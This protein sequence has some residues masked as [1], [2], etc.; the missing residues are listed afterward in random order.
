MKPRRRVTPPRLADYFFF[1]RN[2]RRLN[3]N[4]IYNTQLFNPFAVLVVTALALGLLPHPAYRSIALAIAGLLAFLYVKTRRIAGGVSVERQVAAIARERTELTVTYVITNETAFA[5]SALNFQ[6]EFDGVRA[7]VIEVS[8]PTGVP[9]HTQLRVTKKIFLDAGMGVKAFA[10][11]TLRFR[12]ELGIFDFRT[13]VLQESAVEVFPAVEELPRLRAAVSGESIEFGFYDIAKR[14]DSNLFI[15]TRTYRR[16]DP[17][18]HINWRLS[19]KSDDLVVNEYEKSTNTYVTIVAELGLGEQFGAGD[20]SS[21]EL[22]KDLA[23]GLCQ[24]E[25]RRRNF[26]QVIANNLFVPFDT[27]IRQLQ[28]LE[29]HFTR[30]ELAETVGTAH[31]APLADLPRNGQV[32]YLCPVPLT[33]TTNET[34]ERLGAL[35]ATGQEVVVFL[36][37]PFGE[38]AARTQGKLK[39]PLLELERTG[40]ADL[41]NLRNR[42]RPAGIPVIPVKLQREERPYDQLVREARSLL[43]AK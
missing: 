24:N 2:F 39:L 36:L 20:A 28:L 18:R 27:G 21:W 37:D 15:G 41:A 4:F 11:I 35:R 29:R 30:H 16:G 19:K 33:T 17:V 5:L 26:V 42:L 8:A 3:Y 6:D 31:L 34:I 25:I 10:P 43:E 13:E 40:R 7:G 32:Y 23:L 14:G 12:D 38:L 1:E 22:A 9:A